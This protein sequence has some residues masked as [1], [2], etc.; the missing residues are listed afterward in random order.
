MG[1]YMYVVKPPSKEDGLYMTNVISSMSRVRW[2]VIEIRFN[3]IFNVVECILLSP[4]LAR[5]M[6]L[7]SFG[8]L[9][10]NVNKWGLKSHQMHFIQRP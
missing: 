7:S 6:F 4:I 10:Q 2:K 1:V 8:P 5:G 9:V 3:E